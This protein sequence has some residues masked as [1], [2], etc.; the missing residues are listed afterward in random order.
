MFFDPSKSPEWKPCY[1]LLTGAI[2]PRAIAFVSTISADGVA[3]LA[4][5]SFFTAVCAKPPTV[6]F[7][8][9]RKGDTGEKKDTLRN[10]EATGEFVINVVTEAIAEQMNRCATDF[11]YGVSEFA[12]AGLTARP[13]QL[14]KPPS[15][16]ESPISME[17]RL[18]QVVAVGE[19]PGSGAAVLGEVVGFSVADELVDDFRI[20]L[21]QLAPIGRLAGA[22]YTRV[23]DLFDMTRVPYVSLPK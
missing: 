18:N 9:M 2:V 3:N 8:P 16:A 6:L 10:L 12:E 1:K 13:S 22:S 23:T 19:G 20:D 14:V 21:D 15:V 4:P 11:P 7:C 17:C 5:F